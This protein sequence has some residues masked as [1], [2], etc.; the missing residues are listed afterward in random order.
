MFFHRIPLEPDALK[1]L[2]TLIET[3]GNTVLYPTCSFGNI[4]YHSEHQMTEL[5]LKTTPNKDLVIS[6]I[7]LA[8][9]RIGTGTKILEYLKSFA[10]KNGFTSIVIESTMTP[11]MN[12]FALKHGFAPV[13]HQGFVSDEDHEF[14][15]NYKWDII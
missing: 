1:D 7:A 15:G 12:H 4:M 13:K 10:R 11:A 14:Y 8:N 3:A 9:Q 2:Q 5:Y 6:R